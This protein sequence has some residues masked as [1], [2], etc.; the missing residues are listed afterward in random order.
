MCSLPPMGLVQYLEAGDPLETSRRPLTMATMKLESTI[1][2][3]FKFFFLIIFKN[4]FERERVSRGGAER[5]GERGSQAGS[6]LSAQHG[7]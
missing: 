1:P 5:E 7:T 3:F 6:M 4:Y 2:F